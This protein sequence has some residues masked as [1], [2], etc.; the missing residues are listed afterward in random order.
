MSLGAY[1][2]PTPLQLRLFD[3]RIY[4][5]QSDR[6]DSTLHYP[7]RVTG[8]PG[9]Y[10]TGQT[11]HSEQ[12]HQLRDMAEGG[13]RPSVPSREQAPLPLAVSGVNIAA[14]SG[15]LTADE[16]AEDGTD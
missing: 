10:L 13:V 12:R 11:T 3:G 16:V 8:L 15:I 4:G 5:L 9:L 1:L 7:R 6:T 14:A 2:P